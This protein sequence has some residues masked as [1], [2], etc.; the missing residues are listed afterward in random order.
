MTNLTDLIKSRSR[1][2]NEDYEPRLFDV[3]NADDRADF[4]T[5]LDSDTSIE[6]LDEIHSQLKELVEIINPSKKLSDSESESIII[7]YLNGVPIEEYGK[8]AYYSWNK[9]MIHILPKNEFIS[10]RTN[11]NMYKITQD[12]QHALAKKKIV[13][14]G[15][16]VGNSIATTLARERV[17][18]EL[19]LADFDE[20]ELSNLNRI[21]S[22]V[23]ELGIEKSIN[24]ARQIAL[25]D[26]YIKVRIWRNGASRENLDE[27]LAEE[28]VDL[29]FDECDNLDV[30][31]AIR[32]IARNH[33]IPVMMDTS[34][35]GMLDI[36][37]FDREPNRDIF[38]GLINHLDLDMVKDL[39]TSE[40]K[41]PYILPI[42]GIEKMSQELKISMMEIGE[43]ISTW[44][45]LASAVVGGAG[46]SVDA[47][48]RLLLGQI[49]D[50]G[51][52]YFDS[53]LELMPQEETPQN[54]P[55]NTAPEMTFELAKEI[56]EEVGSSAADDAAEVEEEHLS[57]I[58]EAATWAPSGGNM[59]PWFWYYDE[60]QLYLIHDQA[61]SFSMLD[62]EHR[63]SYMAFGA[64]LENLR[65]K[66]CQLGYGVD[67]SYPENDKVAAVVTFHQD[68]FFDRPYALDTSLIKGIGLRETNRNLEGR[69]KLDPQ[70]LAELN[71]NLGE[72]KS[73][74][75]EDAAII[76]A[77]GCAVGNG[78]RIRLLHEWGH[79]D[80]MNE[81]RWSDAEARD[82]G[83]GV[84]LETVDLTEG[85]KAGMLV[86][87]DW[88]AVKGL[89]EL[90][91]DKGTKFM[92]LTTK[93]FLS[94]SALMLIT[95][96]DESLSTY[97]KAGHLVEQLWIKGNMNGLAIQPVSAALFLHYR[98][99]NDPITFS[100]AE[101]RALA[102]VFD[103]V[104]EAFDLTTEV[105]L[106]LL[107]IGLAG[108]PKRSM[109]KPLNQVFHYAAIANTKLQSK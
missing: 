40:E 109:R 73:H 60:R 42:L 108:S 57:S 45:Q 89:R 46:V 30:K 101:T 100:D 43:S 50:S 55:V 72:C 75:L 82:S 59:Q 88:S 16:S 34:D 28:P 5:L 20:L 37:R 14:I 76:D 104:N 47:A 87:R 1:S 10:V 11:R 51:R 77:L 19:R 97:M 22:T 63:G 90:G 98:A 15:L 105:P 23:D 8:W 44:P 35:A 7:D 103:S 49:H 91:D 39:K 56:A 6:V 36:E 18:G 25:M 85:E 3:S 52:Y 65:L 68:G 93:T 13:V 12:E 2:L 84:D 61:A 80:F 62:F 70:I 31:V 94:A 95:A 54:S 99:Q 24:T 81:M 9:R 83:T 96:E 48:R 58:V 86:A 102:E 33:G 78:D 71:Q 69:G 64:A 106:F 21:S 66:A 53:A 92:E 107:R 27:M 74:I 4:Q 79:H 32:E 41:I 17:C 38:H 26:P 67:F 29:V